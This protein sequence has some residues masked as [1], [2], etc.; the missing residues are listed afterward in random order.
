M[1]E[2]IFVVILGVVVYVA[3]MLSVYNIGITNPNQETIHRIELSVYEKELGKEVGNLKYKC[4]QKG[5]SLFVKGQQ[6]AC[7]IKGGDL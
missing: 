6:S 3:G 5:G 4:L 2:F 7:V 1:K